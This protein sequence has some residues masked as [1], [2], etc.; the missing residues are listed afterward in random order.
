MRLTPD[1]HRRLTRK[2]KWRRALTSYAFL[3][4]NAVFFV[5]FLLIPVAFL[6]FYNF[7]T[8]GIIS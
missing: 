3:L 6:F 4:P 1:E 5:A 2:Y 8:G 7:N